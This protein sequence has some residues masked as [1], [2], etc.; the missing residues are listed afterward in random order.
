MHLEDVGELIM[1]ATKK[2]GRIPDDLTSLTN[3]MPLLPELAQWRTRPYLCPAVR[4]PVD[5]K[6]AGSFGY[7]YVDWSSRQ[8]ARIAD[9]PGE[10]PLVYDNAY[11][12]HQDRGIYVLKVDGS[13]I[14][15]AGGAWLLEFS[16]KHPEYRISVPR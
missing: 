10:Y 12:N 14:W 8:F 9:V 2:Q 16:S 3:L 4:G 7:T 15:D 13:V 11:S 5:P 1:I 6:R